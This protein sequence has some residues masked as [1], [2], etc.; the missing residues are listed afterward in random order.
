M[1]YG[2]RLRSGDLVYSR[3]DARN[4]A[5]A[6]VPDE[7][8]GA[9]VSKDFPTFA[10]RTDLIIPSFLNRYLGTEQFFAQLQ[11][12]SFGTTNR[13]RISEE[14]L[15]SYKIPL[16]PLPEQE[17][18]VRILDE[19]EALRRLH[20]KV[21]QRTD[22]LIPSIFEKMFG[23]V[24]QKQER[25]PP[26]ALGEVCSL[27]SGAT[28][29]TENPDFWSGNIPWVSPKDM[30]SPE[31]YDATDHVSDSAVRASRL[32]LLPKDT[33]L[34]VIRGMI[35]AHTFPVA[36]TRVPIT[37]NQDMKGLLPTNVLVPDYL[38][39][40]LRMSAPKVLSMVSTA[41]HGTKRIESDTIL[42]LPIPIPPSEQQNAFATRIA[43]VHALETT[44][45]AS[46]QLL[47]D[48]FQS[49]LHR[50]FQGEL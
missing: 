5:F 24:A 14:M 10:I 42:N 45:A 21:D 22:K 36:I 15:L 1:K 49:L 32:R 3:I 50:A 13:Q 2:Y 30:K 28:P 25:F 37:I 11:A 47:D 33:V 29:S 44:Q 12:S 19:A 9:V 16:P 7:F 6:L 43:E 40:H 35:L 39:W 26:K 8:D 23:S 31:I 41:G 46:R 17:R 27:V 20:V 38:H 48:L 4:G 34:I 18:I